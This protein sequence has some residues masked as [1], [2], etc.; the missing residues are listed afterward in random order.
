MPAVA[1][2]DD[3]VRTAQVS[4]R[5][6]SDARFHRLFLAMQATGYALSEALGAM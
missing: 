4:S 2:D 6:S 1:D 3:S 5:G